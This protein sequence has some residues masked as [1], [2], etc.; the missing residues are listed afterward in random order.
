MR[1]LHRWFAGAGCVAFGAGLRISDCSE[2]VTARLE[3]PFPQLHDLSGPASLV[4]HRDIRAAA[5]RD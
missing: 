1:S 3:V 4:G 2:R 5:E